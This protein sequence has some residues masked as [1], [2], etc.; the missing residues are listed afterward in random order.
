MLKIFYFVGVVLMNVM[1]G[2]F[3]IKEI[4]NV[5]KV[6]SMLIIVVELVILESEMVV[7]IVKGWIEKIVLGDV[8]MWIFIYMKMLIEFLDCGSDWGELDKCKCLY[9]GLYWYGCCVMIIGRF[10]WRIFWLLEDV[11]VW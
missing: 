7:R 9:W 6:I 3:C 1:L 2:V 10:F 11:N 4:I 5:V 8:S